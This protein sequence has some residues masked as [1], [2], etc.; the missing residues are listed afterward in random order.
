MCESHR[1]E[2][3]STGKDEGKGHCNQRTE[4]AGNN[5]GKGRSSHHSKTLQGLPYPDEQV[6][7]LSW[8][9]WEVRKGTGAGFALLNINCRKGQLQF[10]G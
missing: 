1:Q 5:R 7:L 6:S 8:H 4:Q 10:K 9:E 3:Q 2:D